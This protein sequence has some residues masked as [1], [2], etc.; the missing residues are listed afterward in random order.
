MRD[1]TGLHVCNHP[2]LQLFCCRAR[3][4]W[5]DWVRS[6]NSSIPVMAA[7][8]LGKKRRQSPTK[9]FETERREPHRARHGQRRPLARK[10]PRERGETQPEWVQL[11]GTLAGSQAARKF[12]RPGTGRGLQSV[13]ALWVFNGQRLGEKIEATAIHWVIAGEMTCCCAAY[14]EMKKCKFSLEDH[15]DHSTFGPCKGS[16][17]SGLVLPTEYHGTQG[18]GM[19]SVGLLTIPVEKRAIVGFSVIWTSRTSG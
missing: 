16:H 6:Y 5:R 10:I 8:V 18:L 13:A 11:N 12:R 2:M 14:A 1:N 15:A 17:E 3:K 7:S 9:E 4:S 19:C